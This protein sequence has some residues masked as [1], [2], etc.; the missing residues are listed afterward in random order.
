MNE[1]KVKGQW[2]QLAGKLKAKWGKLTDDDLT[3]SDGTA[4]YLEG[5]I[6]ERYGVARDEAKRQVRE[7]SS[8]L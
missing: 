6:Q 1:D 2:K 5:K 3:V 4:E 7:F 8:R